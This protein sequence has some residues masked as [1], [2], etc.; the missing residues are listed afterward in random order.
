M[1][2]ASLADFTFHPNAA[3]Q[4]F[5]YAM[6]HCQS[7]ARAFSRFFRREI[8][9]EYPTHEFRRD[10]VPRIPDTDFQMGARPDFPQGGQRSFIQDFGRHAQM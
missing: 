8:R 4:G 5:Q 7:H 2:N 3:V 9:L 6:N 10:T 1:K